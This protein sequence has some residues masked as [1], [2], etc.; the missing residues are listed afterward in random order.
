MLKFLRKYNKWLLVV[1]GSF[2]M[3]SFL[4]PQAIQQI[5]Q[6]QLGRTTAVVAG[7][8]ISIGERQRIAGEHSALEQ[9][10]D[11]LEQLG[12]GAQIRPAIGADEEHWLLL[13]VAAEEGGF[14]GGPING[15]NWA[16][17]TFVQPMAQTFLQIDQQ[18]RQFG[19]EVPE[20]SFEQ[21]V[22]LA[23]AQ[24]QQTMRIAGSSIVMGGP[25][26]FE[27]ALAKLQGV[28][29]MLDSYAGANRVSRPRT[30]RDAQRLLDQVVVDVALIP[31]ALG[32]GPDAPEPSEADLVA[33]FAEYR[34]VRADQA[35][36]GIG[37]RQ[38]PRVKLEWLVLDPQA[39]AQG[40]RVNEVEVRAELKQ[41][42]A[43]YPE[44]EQEALDQIRSERRAQQAERLVGQARALIRGD[45]QKSLEDLQRQGQFYTVPAGWEPMRMSAIAEDVQRNIGIALPEVTV[46]DREWLTRSS[47]AQLPGIGT[48][49][50]R[51]GAQALSFPEAVLSVREIAEPAGLEMPLGLQVGVPATSAEAVD[52]RGRIYFFTVLDAR[53][54]SPADALD[55]VREQVEQGYDALRGLETLRGQ[56]S[57]ILEAV[58]V[59][60]LEALK[61]LYDPADEEEGTERGEVLIADNLRVNRESVVPSPRSRDFMSGGLAQVL[62]VESFRDAVFAAAQAID[63]TADPESIEAGSRWLSVAIPQR[64]FM[65]VVKIEAVRP[66]TVERYRTE[67]GPGRAQQARIEEIGQLV[68]QT[69][70]GR[71][72]AIVLSGAFSPARLAERLEYRDLDARDEDEPAATPPAPARPGDEG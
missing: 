26:A 58:R 31:A 19:Q 70:V 53:G 56:E 15:A 71:R 16:L 1:F 52:A 9:F 43:A 8:E 24:L 68:E 4:A 17:E 44:D 51:V 39:I 41:N 64:R 29:Q 38:P 50:V 67:W 34:D 57:A 55:E 6:Q 10:F 3:V 62:D 2:L 40:V 47:L 54:E 12:I 33:H 5:G 59:D 7:R 35:E 66:L 25:D 65:A 63:P 23:E 28:L 72:S 11:Q 60:G 45:V 36:N 20:R 48:S 30:L 14:V 37:Y 21:Y 27:T 32:V 49:A 69:R 61:G 46:R 22:Q 18:R 13:S 42:R